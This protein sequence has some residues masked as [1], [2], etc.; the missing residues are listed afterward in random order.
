MDTLLSIFFYLHV[1]HVGE[2]YTKA[3]ILR[4]QTIYEKPI[5]EIKTNDILLCNI[6]AAYQPITNQ[7]IIPDNVEN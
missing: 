4:L 2:T 7:I 3:D 5:E 6:L 1:L